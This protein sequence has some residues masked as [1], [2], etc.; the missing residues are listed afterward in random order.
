MTA[1][2]LA[3]RLIGEADRAALRLQMLYADG[4]FGVYRRLFRENGISRR[5]ICELDPLSLL[6]R[7]PALRG[8]RFREVVDEGIRTSREVV[9]I[10]VSSG[11][12]GLP[13]RRI[14]TRRDEAAEGAALA[15][16]F[17]VCGIGP[18]DSVACVDTGPLTL[19]ASFMTAL[20]QLGV[21][22]A[23][24]FS[25]SVD[26]DATVAGLSKLKPSVVLTIPSIVERVMEPLASALRRTEWRLSKVVYVGEPMHDATRRTLEELGVEAF[27]YYG[28]SETSTLGIECAAHEGIHLWTEWNVVEIIGKDTGEAL[29]TT[30]GREGLPLFRYALGDTLQAREGPC[31]CG[32]G[33]P[34]VDALGRTDGTVSA[35]G[36]KLSYDVVRRAAL[37]RLAYDGPISVELNG[38]GRDRMVVMLPESLAMHEAS[39]VRSMNTVEPDLAYLI[40]SG[41]L[42][43]DVS[44]VEDRSLESRKA[45]R[46]VDRRVAHA[47]N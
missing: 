9:D 47:A 11:T 29:V 45:P 38:V 3:A 20:E 27:A 5:D 25:V 40:A 28:A 41:F 32:L 39:I 26:E 34:R 8:E 15:R 43:L 10:E 7:L 4:A 36:V 13:K 24:A 16:M 33:Y 2:P 35:L 19:M 6:R 21:H 12:T 31:P 46:I 23:Y 17:E 30:L 18:G 44:F 1:P 14:I 37:W 22:D 42:D